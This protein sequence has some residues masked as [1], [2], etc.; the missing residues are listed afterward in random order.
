MEASIERESLSVGFVMSI[1][2][3]MASSTQTSNEPA[4]AM[5]P[6]ITVAMAVSTAGE[7]VTTRNPALEEPDESEPDVVLDVVEPESEPRVEDSE[8]GAPVDSVTAGPA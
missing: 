7:T 8:P 4:P 2:V 1:I 3:C 5:A 6:N